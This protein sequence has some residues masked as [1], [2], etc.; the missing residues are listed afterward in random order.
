MYVLMCNNVIANMC[1]NINM[2]NDNMCNN[3]Y[4]LICV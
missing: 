2:C 3:M 1:N 4:V